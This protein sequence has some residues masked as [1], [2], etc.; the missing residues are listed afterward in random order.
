M[1]QVHRDDGQYSSGTAFHHLNSLAEKLSGAIDKTLEDAQSADF[2]PEIKSLTEHFSDKASVFQSWRSLKKYS[3]L[4]DLLKNRELLIEMESLRREGKHD[5]YNFLSAL[6][7][8]PDSQIRV[9]E[10]MSFWKEPGRFFANGQTSVSPIH[11]TQMPHLDLN[12]G[13][14]R[15]ALVT[16]SIDSVQALPTFKATYRIPKKYSG[17]SVHRALQLALGSRAKGISGEAI[18]VKKLFSEVQKILTSEGLTVN[19]YLQSGTATRTAETKINNEL[20]N[21][22]YG[23]RDEFIEVTVKLNAKSDPDGLIAGNDTAS[24]MPFGSE[25]NNVYMCNPNCALLTVQLKTEQGSMRTIA[26]S[27]V[28]LDDEYSVE[29]AKAAQKLLSASSRDYHQIQNPEFRRRAKLK[30]TCDNIETAP[31]YRTD[32]F[33]HIIGA[34]YQIFLRDYVDIVGDH[35]VEMDMAYVGLGYTATLK[36]LPR[37]NNHLLPLSPLSYSDNLHPQVTCIPLVN[38]RQVFNSSSEVYFKP[39]GFLE[40]LYREDRIRPLSYLDTFAVSSIEHLRYQ[41]AMGESFAEIANT[42][43]A[44]QI[45]NSFHDRP[46]LS[47]IADDEHGQAQAYILAYEG[48]FEPEL[49]GSSVR[50]PFKANDPIIYIADMASLEGRGQSAVELIARFMK[51]YKEIYL[52]N[53]KELPIVA[54]FRDST[55]YRLLPQIIKRYQKTYGIEFE[56]NELPTYK[57][58]KSIMHPVVLIPREK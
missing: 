41:S 19:E 53:G 30:I 21:T 36:H 1:R 27:V 12:P 9:D 46:N 33:A 11:Y 3:E 5:L 52:N 57:L 48:R 14:L 8:R 16:G 23:L 56:I 10:L 58:G 28:T 6:A 29:P 43:T 50:L 4:V 31:N 40:S 35:G 13:Q 47:Y 32:Q 15:D 7:F 49:D 39:N 2:I 22:S 17:I 44:M 51:D 20:F 25:K 55:S 24:C 26:Q 54:E 34:A 42:I 18:N 37:K 38:S 45:S